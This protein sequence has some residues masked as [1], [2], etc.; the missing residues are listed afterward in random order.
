MYLINFFRTKIL[1]KNLLF[2]AANATYEVNSDKTDLED[3]LYQ[4]TSTFSAKLQQP[5]NPEDKKID[6]E[7]IKSKK[8]SSF[9]LDKLSQLDSKKFVNKEHHV[10]SLN[11]QFS[12]N[13]TELNPNPDRLI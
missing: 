10:N 4:K 12:N 1:L 3:V 2:L 5:L 6:L 8:R 13:K 11:N 9:L 7:A